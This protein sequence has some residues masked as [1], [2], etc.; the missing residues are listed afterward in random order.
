MSSVGVT[1]FQLS[2][3]RYLLKKEKEFRATCEKTK[4]DSLGLLS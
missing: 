2:R 4:D 1:I 3:L